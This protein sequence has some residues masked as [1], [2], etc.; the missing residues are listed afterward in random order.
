METTAPPA[1]MDER[2]AANYLDIGVRFMQ[3]SRVRGD[4]PKFVK[5]GGRVRYRL[6]D[7]DAFIEAHVVKSTAQADRLG[8]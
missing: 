3:K 8:K 2:A 4:G 5:V 1:L 6:A 7:L